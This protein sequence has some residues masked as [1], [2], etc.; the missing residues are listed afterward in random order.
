VKTLLQ[1][2]VRTDITGKQGPM[3]PDTLP[4]FPM[5]EWIQH[6][7]GLG[8]AKVMEVFS[9]AESHCKNVS[10]AKADDSGAARIIR[11]YAAVLTAWRLLCDF[12]GID[13]G[14]GDFVTCTIREMN[15][16]V[17]ETES[18]RE[19]WVWIMDIIIGEIDRGAY[20]S[21]FK[22]ETIS[23]T[24]CLLLRLPH[25]MQHISQTPALKDKWNSL[26]VKQDR[27]LKRQLDRAGVIHTPDLERSIGKM[28]VA[29]CTALSI[30][31]LNNYGLHPSVPDYDDV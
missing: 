12:A 9:A 11:N 26:P 27:V 25:V 21:P 24:P 4:R 30:P 28:R 20:Q 6:L 5:R 22:F 14:Q 31:A 18:D 3:M 13:K 19:P 7:A 29:H 10:A 1:K 23:G 15:N 16:H 17:K 2:L 8:K